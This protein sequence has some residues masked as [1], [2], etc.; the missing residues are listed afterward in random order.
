[1]LPTTEI[2]WFFAGDVPAAVGAWFG[3]AV[4]AAEPPAAR[5]DYYLQQ[6][7]RRDDLGVKLREG[8]VEVKHLTGACGE[9]RDRKSTRLNSSH[10]S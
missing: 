4:P 1:M 5:R 3:R 2:R 10:Y 7:E 8:R 9:L 6:A